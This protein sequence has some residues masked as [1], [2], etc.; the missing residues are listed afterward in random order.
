MQAMP[1]N[2]TMSFMQATPYSRAVKRCL[3]AGY[4]RLQR[5]LAGDCS[6]PLNGAEACMV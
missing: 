1:D 2:S 4:S 3:L 6:D 5:P